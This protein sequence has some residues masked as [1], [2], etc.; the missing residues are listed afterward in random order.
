MSGGSIEPRSD[1]KAQHLDH[2]TLRIRRGK[3]CLALLFLRSRR[4]PLCDL[5]N[6]VAAEFL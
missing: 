4:I 2:L 1:Q 5:V 6:R 3:A